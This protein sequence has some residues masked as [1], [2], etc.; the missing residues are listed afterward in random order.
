VNLVATW[1]HAAPLE[2]APKAN[3]QGAQVL[4]VNAVKASQ[5]DLLL[6]MQSDQSELCTPDEFCTEN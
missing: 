3:Y 5:R 2:E 4:R 6:K 1:C